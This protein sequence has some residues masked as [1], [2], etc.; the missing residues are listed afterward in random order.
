M[1]RYAMAISA[2]AMGA[3]LG[4]F[5]SISAL[6]RPLFVQA[7]ELPPRPTLSVPSPLQAS[8]D[9][10]QGSSAQDRGRITGTVIED[11]S[12]VPTSGI[13]VEVGD[14]VVYTDAN[15]NY[16]RGNLS[17]GVY[18]VTLQMAL[19][20]GQPLQEPI[21]VTVEAQRTV[22][23][24][25]SFRRSE[26]ASALE[27]PVAPQ[28]TVEITIPRQLPATGGP[29]SSFFFIAVSGGAMIISG[30]VMRRRSSR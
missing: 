10:A 18:T 13:G 15:G 24:H 11:Q 4:A 29:G 7:Q 22:V 23:Q 3:S 17:P 27:T 20:Q 9:S 2:L 21:R 1:H 28:P 14:V 8:D 5:F 19:D 12:G 26:T 16:D 30:V 25:L 6:S